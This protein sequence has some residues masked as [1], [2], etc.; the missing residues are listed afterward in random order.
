MAM[1]PQRSSAMLHDT[2]RTN[3]C[4]L[5]AKNSEAEQTK[6]MLSAHLP[7]SVGSYL[8]SIKHPFTCL[9][10]QNILSPGSSSGKH[11]SLCLFLQDIL[12]H[13]CPSKTSFDITDFPKKLEVSTSI[14]ASEP[15]L[16]VTETSLLVVMRPREHPLTVT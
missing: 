14:S 2:R 12:S 9:L 16:T 11:S 13:V 10:Y 3:A 6:P 4:M 15:C 8:Y 1:L 7:L 5:L